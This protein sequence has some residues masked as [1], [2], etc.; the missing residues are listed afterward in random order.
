MFL[1]VLR[2]L[3]LQQNLLPDQTFLTS[4]KYPVEFLLG[5]I[6]SKRKVKVVTFFASE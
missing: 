2:L 4:S 6:E 1:N 3:N 5:P